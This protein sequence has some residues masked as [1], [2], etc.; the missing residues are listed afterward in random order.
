MRFAKSAS[1]P[2]ASLKATKPADLPVVQ[3]TKFELVINPQTARILGLAVPPTLLATGRRGDRVAMVRDYLAFGDIEGKL[4]TLDVECTKCD[5]KG[6]YSVAKLIERYGPDS[7]MQ[8][9]RASLSADCPKRH[10]YAIHERCDIMCS[11]L[12]R[13]A[14]T[15][16][17]GR[18]SVGAQST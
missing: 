3:A 9:W 15:I 18:N 16:S 10:A 12:P 7:N 14:V 11:D 13:G 2:V 5:R 8:T 1:T 4:D 17:R 6:R